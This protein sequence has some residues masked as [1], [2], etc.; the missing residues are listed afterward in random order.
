MPRK[1]AELAARDA[2]RDLEAELREEVARLKAGGV[3]RVTVLTADGESVESSVARARLSTGMSQARFA[4]LLGV[5]VR[6]L[7]Q[8][9][10]GRR[11]P[12]GAARTL[13]RVAQRNP[14]VLAGLESE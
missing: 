13:L 7:Q 5:S 14:A 6:T 3:G 1:S 4:R 2:A 8:W 9:E 10:Q 12:T 11:E